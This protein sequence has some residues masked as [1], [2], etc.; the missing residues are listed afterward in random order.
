MKLSTVSETSDTWIT[1][2]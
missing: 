2:R 1:C